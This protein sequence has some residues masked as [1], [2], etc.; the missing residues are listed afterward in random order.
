MKY[1]KLHH[2]KC[3]C[4]AEIWQLPLSGTYLVRCKEQ[5]CGNKTKVH[6][7]EEY[8]VNVWNDGAWRDGE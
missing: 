3:G 1:P 8:A 5:S 6:L 4:D 7:S 2:C